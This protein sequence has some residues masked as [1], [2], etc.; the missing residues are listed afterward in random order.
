MI[1]S[2]AIALA[3]LLP[4][5]TVRSRCESFRL[6]LNAGAN[7]HLSLDRSLAESICSLPNPRN[8]ALVDKLGEGGYLEDARRALETYNYICCL[9]GTVSDLTKLGV[10]ILRSPDA[11]RSLVLEIMT[12]CGLYEGSPSFAREVG[13]PTK[14]GVS[15]AVLAAVE[16]EGAIACYSPPSTSGAILSPV[17]F[18]CG[19]SPARPDTSPDAPDPRSPPTRSR[20][21]DRIGKLAPNYPGNLMFLKSH[22]SRL[23]ALILAVA[24]GL[25]GCSSS[26]SGLSGDYGRDTLQVIETLDKALDLP[27]DAPDGKEVRSLA[28]AR[29]NDYIALYR[30]DKNSGGLR[31][32]TT[33][34][35]ALN[36]LA[37]Y[38]TAY[39]SRPVPEKLKDRLKQEFKQVQFSLQKG[40]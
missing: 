21:L 7:C 8:R 19:R 3:D 1:N 36:S 12:T 24:I 18:S 16:R 22:L 26:P 34:Q 28:R 25:M 2:G 17:Y 29:I 33:M 27:R 13:F 39:G 32:F 35:T 31:S 4:G 11:I 37:G 6:W 9:S 15:G 40:V 10:L 5:T 30:K 14:S 20:F 38:Y 23:L